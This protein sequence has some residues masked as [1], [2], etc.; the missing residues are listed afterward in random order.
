MATVSP[1]DQARAHSLLRHALS[2][3]GMSPDSVAAVAQAALAVGAVDS[4]SP[5]EAAAALAAPVSPVT[6]RRIV[7]GTALTASVTPIAAGAAGTSDGSTAP[8]GAASPSDGSTTPAGPVDPL[9]G[10]ITSATGAAGPRAGRAVDDHLARAR[11]LLSVIEGLTQTAARLDA[12]LVLAARHQTAAIGRSLLAERDI[13]S[14]EDLSTS[15]RL[16]WRARAKALS[17]H[18]IEAATGWGSGEVVDLVGL[19]TAP[20]P[21]AQPVIEAM[22]TGAAPWRLARSFWRDCGAL[23]ADEAAHVAE[24]LFGND[25]DTCA[26]ERLAPD[27]TLS[28]APW[29][30]REFRAALRREVTRLRSTDLAAARAARE[31]ALA[32]RSLGVTIDENGTGTVT[33]LGSALQ[34]TAIADRVDQAARRARA[35]GDERTLAQLRADIGLALMM[36]GTVLPPDAAT[37]PGADGTQESTSGT[38]LHWTPDLVQVLSGMPSATLQVVVPYAAVHAGLTPSATSSVTR[39]PSDRAPTSVVTPPDGLAPIRSSTPAGHPTP[40][41]SSTPPDGRGPTPSISPSGDPAPDTSAPGPPAPPPAGLPPAGELLTVGQVLGAHSAYLSVD[42]IHDLALLPGTVLERLLVD[43]A[44]G[45]CVERSIDR[46]RP[47]AAMRAQILAADVTCRAP[48]CLVPAASC[49][50]D[51][52]VEHGS[53]EGITAET[54]LAPLHVGHHHPKTLKAWDSSLAENRDMTWTS[55]LGRLYR[56]RSHDY[57]QYAHL[58]TDAFDRVHGAATGDEADR[59]PQVDR[60]ILLALAFRAAGEGL[61][62]GDDAVEPDETRFGGW[63]FVSLTHT[64]ERGIRRSGPSGALLA[65]RAAAQAASQNPTDAQTPEDRAAHPSPDRAVDPSPDRATHPSHDGAIG[66]S[67][68]RRRRSAER[69]RRDEGPPPF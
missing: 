43:P 27:G 55:L 35:S 44:D 40:T 23:A 50:L 6:A 17:R 42:Q 47:D 53:P 31:A 66:T 30:H 59:L 58:V 10:S 4:G 65:E 22:S 5:L 8:A 69:L 68:D 60:E 19:A 3:T 37:P 63:G 38:G 41:H 48:G 24:V 20:L 57:R 16:R 18:E 45:R 39:A 21:A 14:P 15:Q 2:M 62:A 12:A 13:S 67:P 26:P 64:D 61:Q 1:A 34:A 46:Y 52:V 49:Q 9:A 11:A 29:F 54:N 56:T 28:E 25:A 32:S 7:D 33:L 36:H 51:H